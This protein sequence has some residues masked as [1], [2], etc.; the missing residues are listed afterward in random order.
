MRVVN[1]LE[2]IK[3]RET[4]GRRLFLVAVLSLGSGLLVTF[5]PNLEGFQAAAE[6]NAMARILTENYAV[7]SFASLI[8]GFLAASVGSFFINRF[9]PRRWPNSKVLERPDEAFGRLIKGL[10][11]QYTLYN[12]VV[13][14]VSHLLVGPCGLLTFVVRSDKGELQVVGKK[15]KEPFTIGRLFTLFAR[16][17]VGNP[18]QEIAE[19]LKA[20]IEVRDD[21]A[22][23]NQDATQYSQIPVNGAAAFVHQDLKLK[24]QDPTV[25][26]LLPKS[27][28][29]FVYEQAREAG[30]KNSLMRQFT[31]D[32]E[33]ELE[34][35]GISPEQDQE[36]TEG[37]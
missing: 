1:N 17:G 16:E 19:N 15:W 29:K 24:V 4:L 28:Q 32:L 27:V 7:F 23:I 8:I 2:Y 25:P 20:M 13:P 5:T 14:G 22:K 21:M 30:V 3:K 31:Q 35:A 18:P 36:L 34:A 11:D 12:W 26:I 9:A 37:T 33:K 6:R 10:N